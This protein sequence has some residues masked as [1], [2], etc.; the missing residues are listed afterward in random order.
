MLSSDHL[1][2]LTTLSRLL[3]LTLLRP[4]R[5]TTQEK[6]S[7]LIS[8]TLSRVLSPSTQMLRLNHGLTIPRL[9]RLRT[10]VKVNLLTS[11]TLSKDH[12]LSTLM[13]RRVPKPDGKMKSI[14]IP[15]LLIPTSLRVLMLELMSFHQELL[16]SLV[17]P[18][19]GAKKSMASGPLIL[20]SLLVHTAM[21]TRELLALLSARSHTRKRVIRRES[22]LRNIRKFTR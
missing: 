6:E 14:I 12:S 19:S 10:Q 20:T 22:T 5:L 17:R 8:P 11:P 4:E 16:D 2:Q 13:L 18:L 7:L 1:A 9:Q 15:T 3:G 21:L